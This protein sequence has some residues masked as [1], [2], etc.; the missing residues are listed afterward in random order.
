M[1]EVTRSLE[2]K[3]FAEFRCLGAECEDTCCDGWAVAIDRPTYEKYQHCSDSEWR[4]RFQ[5]LI[6]INT[7][8]RTEHDYA[9]IRLAT[10]TCPFLSEGLCSIHKEMG[11]AYLS[12]TCASYPRVWNAVDGVLEKS[13]DLGCP[14]AVRRALLDPAPMAFVEGPAGASDFSASRIAVIDTGSTS[15]PG[16]PYGH[17]RA[18]RAFVMW[19]L[20]NRGFPLWKRLVVLGLFCDKLQEM[21]PGVTEPQLAELLEAYQTAVSGGLFEDALNQLQPQP[22]VRVET[23]VELIVARIT[24]D[25]TNRRFLGCY[26]EFM[27]GI[28]WGPASTMDEI[29][30]R[31]QD[32]HSRYCAPFLSGHEHML[33]HYLV[34]YVRRNLFPFGPQESTYQLHDQSIDRSIHGEFMLMAVYYSLIEMLLGGMAGLHKEA[35]GEAQVIQVI[36]TLT[37]TFEHSLTFPQRVLAVLDEKGLHN[38]AGVAT[39]VKN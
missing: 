24:S 21:V 6:T 19:L 10:T 8:T 36:Y 38:P 12:V 26:K 39:L 4:A 9:R 18:V 32:A 23:L 1:R 27:D 15:H 31:Y 37:R 33:E 2:P 34:N 5:R 29:C 25:F 3:H 30:A 17:F 22:A 28:Q 14:E 7:G 16:K 20:Q 35:F 13:L 11:E